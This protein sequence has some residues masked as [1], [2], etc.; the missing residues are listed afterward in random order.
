MP[1]MRPR[2]RCFLLLLCMT[3]LLTSLFSVIAGAL[4]AAPLHN[5]REVS[6]MNTSDRLLYHTAAEE[7]VYAAGNDTRTVPDF[8]VNIGD[9]FTLSLVV[10]TTAASGV[11]VFFAKGPKSAGHYELWMLD[12]CFAFYA[13]EINGDASI[14]TNV[15]IADGKYHQV[16]FSLHAGAWKCYLDGVLAA[17]GMTTGAVSDSTATLTV[18]AL[19]DGTFEYVGA[20]CD[21][22]IHTGELTAA[23]LRE[24]MPAYVEPG[25]SYEPIERVSNYTP[26]AYQPTEAL[27]GLDRLTYLEALPYI[28][29]TATTG[30]EGSIS[31]WGDNADWDWHI[32]QDEHDEWVLFE[33]YGAGCIYNMTQ[34]RY[35]VAEDPVFSFYFDDSETPAFR[36]KL[37]EFGQKA[38][39][40][41]PLSAIYEGPDDNG[42]GPIW[43]VRSFVPMEFTSYCKVTSSVKLEGNEKSQGGG[44]G[45]ISYVLYDTAEGLETFD[46]AK[47][48]LDRLIGTTA[49][50]TFDPKYAAENVTELSEDILVPAGRSVIVLDEDGAGSLAALKLIL[51]D[52]N[53]MAENLSS[54]RLRLYWD[55]HTT[56][57]VDAPIG[58]FFGNEYG[59]TTCDNTLLMLGTELQNGQYFRGYNYFPMPYWS[60][61]RLELYNVGATDIIVDSIEVQITPDSVRS[62]DRETTGYF[63]S[64]PYYEVTPNTM[65]QNSII[66]T[67]EGTG[68]MVYGVLSGYGIA[69]G[70]EGDVRV[71][72]D[73]RLSPEME[74]DGSESWASYG[75]GFVDPPQ[76][77]P[78]SGYNGLYNSNSYWSEVR[79]TLGDSY[80][81]RD[82]LVFELEHGCQNDGGGSHSGQIFCYMLPGAPKGAVTD[83]LDLGDAASREA[84]DYTVGGKYT[85]STITSAY[86][87]GLNTANSF[88]GI[89]HERGTD[90]IT[91]TLAIDPN[92]AGVILQRTSSQK[93]GRQLAEVFIDGVKLDTPW[94]VADSNPHYLWLD[95]SYTIPVAYTY[96]KSAIT[97]TLRPLS[98]DGKRTYWNAASFA[99]LSVLAIQSYVPPVE[100]DTP[101]TDTLTAGT[102]PV[103]P[104]DETAPA[105]TPMDPATEPASPTTPDTTTVAS[106]K[107]CRSR[108]A[109]VAG[110]LTALTLAAG[111]ALLFVRRR[112]T[113]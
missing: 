31:K 28:D 102:T 86:A 2:N 7:E 91:F 34:H 45:H 54:L 72:F 38:P 18:G 50:L 94:Y 46:P 105:T 106:D 22:R 84:H 69:A 9:S 113:R 56:P 3:L 20:L 82:S 103:E 67:M 30:Y 76:S 85:E 15:F 63:T 14:Y 41:E 29:L 26:A 51:R 83:T 57:D 81:F 40:L 95:D 111:A 19:N 11:Q 43:V 80:Y 100:T 60:H 73:G 24:L 5:T 109:G 44:W 16:T 68:H 37:S 47:L 97:V 10:K 65:G 17:S 4:D 39:F 52:D 6:A 99:A 101:P 74:S 55:G 23:E 27:R 104:T 66:A 35:P 36:I 93:N 62:Y 77:N 88:V 8:D 25:K 112:Q 70:C 78:F 90:D 42:R 12:G 92:N 13:P 21:I 48:D 49:N 110:L 87:N 59:N 33:T 107:G 71:F 108:I 64:S 32:Y 98:A 61:V 1:A 53:A 75:W 89:I 79:L 58:T 96:G